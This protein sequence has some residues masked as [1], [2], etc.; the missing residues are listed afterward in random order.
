MKQKIL[1][2][3]IIV[4]AIFLRFWQLGI[5][6]PSLTWD[7]VAWGYNAYSIGTDARDEFGRFLPV[8]YL[9]SFGDFKPPVYAYL[10]VLP[11][12][13]FGLAEFATRFPSALF[14][15]LTVLVTYFLTKRIFEKSL[16]ASLYGLLA[17]GVLAISPWH[18]MLSRAAFEANV[19]TFFLVSGIWLFLGGVQE[20]KWY[21]PLSAI[22]FAI[23]FYT[24]N[25]ERIVTPLIVVV[26]V[27]GFY[28]RLWERKKYAVIAGAV[29][30]ALLLPT[31]PFLLSPQA[32]LR[33]QEVNIFTDPT[34]VT[35]SNQE[36]ANDG[37]VWWSKVIHNRRIGYS[38]LFIRH[39]VDNLRPDFLFYT[40]DGNP[41]FSTQQNGELYLWDLPFFIGGIL[42]LFRKKEGD[43]WILPL[44]LILGIIP[45]AT[46]RETPHALRT[47]ATLPTFQIFIAYGVAWFGLWV[48]KRRSFILKNSIFGLV[49]IL[50]FANWFY[51][52][53]DY[54][55]SYPKEF[56]SEWQYGYKDAY[57]YAKSVEGNYQKIQMTQ[58][59]GRPYIYYLFYDKIS[60]FYFRA[61][62]TVH[63]D[64]FGF[65]DV[66]RVGKYYFPTDFNYN[67]KVRT[68]YFSTIKDVPKT[69]RIL[70]TFQNLD[71]SPAL[72]AYTM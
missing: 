21:L 61:N 3:I 60:P 22:S 45:A 35:T 34:V 51:F 65:V 44:W 53:Y 4:V 8:T 50:L 28:K 18:F 40:G 15:V 9:E 29:G 58:A 5:N 31:V 42:L 30:L 56:S 68:L 70:K 24:F 27:I 2:L 13:A 26:L 11:I 55:V 39:Y 48:A 54:N 41:K 1:L 63:R 59:L 66:E 25:T 64:A 36:I 6:P 67:N 47:E 17:A 46:A 62:S 12:K 14:G 57:A 32:K 33:F 52:F 10:D 7:E 16:H 23:T 37:N 72:V 71:G 38:L 43:W 19:A 20:K 49:A 69:A